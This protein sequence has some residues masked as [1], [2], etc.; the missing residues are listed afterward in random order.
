M[1]CGGCGGRRAVAPKLPTTPQ[2]REQIQSR[3]QAASRAP[4]RPQVREF[5]GKQQPAVDKE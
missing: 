4:R 1:A 3:M 5:T 2:T